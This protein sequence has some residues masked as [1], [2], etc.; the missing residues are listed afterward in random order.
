MFKEQ[1][2]LQSANKAILSRQNIIEESPF[3][4]L[5]KTQ[6]AGESQLI[7]IS[8]IILLLL[9]TATFLVWGL[10]QLTIIQNNVLSVQAETNSHFDKVIPAQRGI[11]FD[12]N[13]KP[14]LEN[15][16]EYSLTIDTK[17]VPLEDIAVNYPS[18]TSSIESYSRE[19]SPDTSKTTTITLTSIPK[20][21]ALQVLSN[22]RDGITLNESIGRFYPYRDIFSHLL[23]YTGI[24]SETDKAE[25]PYLSNIAIVGKSGLEYQYDDILRGVD[26]SV[27]TKKDALGEILEETTTRQEPVHGSDLILSIDEKDQQILYQKLQKYV[28]QYHAKGG[29][30]VIVKV[31]S[32]AIRALVSYPSYDNNLFAQ[33]ISTNDY[34]KLVDNP[35]TPL[36]FRPLGAQEPPGSTFKTVVGSS[37][38]QSNSIS[39]ST[40][41]NAPGVITLQG[42][43]Q[44][45]DYRKRVQGNLDVR[46]ALMVS[47]NIFFCKTMLK[48]GIDTFLPYAEKFHIGKLT[49]IDLPGETKGRIPSPQNKIWLANNGA[50]WLDPIWYPEGDACNSAIGQGITLA[51]PLQMAMVAATIANGG[52]YYEPRVVAQ[53]KDTKGQSTTIEPKILEQGFISPENL[54]IIRQGMR[55]AVNGPRAIISTMKTAPV[56]V[57]AKTGT[58]EFG[59]KDKNGY[60]T[61]HA[62]II[63]FYP[64]E[65]PEYAFAVLLEGGDDSSRASNLFKEFLIEAYK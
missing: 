25:R 51:T 55:M 49:G 15:T 11:I 36:L 63:G 17:K 37:A 40:I 44:F 27:V 61:S 23:G 62:W 6:K 65:K 50:S 21:V 46:S 38:L 47:S 41:F 48:M 43:T 2:F 8:L 53:I 59:I 7:L 4:A 39:S 30:A 54:A 34:K 24:L 3:S 29:S 19:N 60:L 22:P 20:D 45:Q 16:K 56:T 33:G 14:L 1:K 5:Q 31:D 58:A 18:L 42:G 64:Y 28:D 32:G 26:G 13:N 52:T 9:G 57:A 10:A 12:T 35:Q